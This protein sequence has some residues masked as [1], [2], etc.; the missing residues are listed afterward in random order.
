[1]RISRSRQASCAACERP[2]ARLHRFAA[3][4]AFVFER[5]AARIE[6]VERDQAAI[7]FGAR[8]RQ[9][10]LA[11]TEFARDFGGLF[12]ETLAA[13]RGFLRAGALAFELAEQIGMFAMRALDAA[14]RLR[15]ARARRP[16]ALRG[17]WRA[18][19]SMSRVF[20]SLRASSTRSCL[21]RCS[22]SSTP[23]CGSP[24]RL[25][26]SQ[27]R[28][29]HS[30]VRVMTDSSS[31][32][33]R[34]SRSASAKRFGEPHARQQPHDGGRAAD[35]ARQHA[36]VAIGVHVPAGLQQRDAADRQRRAARRPLRRV[37]RRTTLRDSRRARFRRRVPSRRSPTAARRAAAACRDP[38]KSATRRCANRRA[39][40]PP[41]A[42]L[43]ARRLRAR[44]FSRSVRAASRWL[45]G[46]ELRGAQFLRAVERRGS[47]PATAHRRCCAPAIPSRRAAPS[48]AEDSC[49]ISASRSTAR[50]S[51]CAGEPA[52]LVFELL[53]ARA[54]H[55]RGLVRGALLAI[56]SFP[57]LL[58]VGE[59]V[60]GGRQ[61]FAE[62]A[63]GGLRLRE[64][65]RQLFD[66][67]AQRG[68]F[69]LV[70][71]DVRVRARPAW[72]APARARCAAARAARA[73]A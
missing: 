13:Q 5:R 66:L 63:L 37:R 72:R 4:F 26:R 14:L 1:M 51:A 2:R 33:S 15:R 30:P 25:T 38:R 52:Q 44:R 39:A 67:G 49:A 46:V 41:S 65:R 20:S 55:L 16:R 61:V 71:I 10:V 22:R 64:V 9:R 43:R 35:H 31:A 59:R 18:R 47:A 17:R 11:E 36:G 29:I 7:E 54:L 45:L 57:A 69:A 19:A 8:A 58:P 3:F 40:A 42:V 32:S 53:D 50:R 23:E 27:S 6:R 62:R 24:P 68:D 48:S 34:R 21:T 73:C 56:E 12:F 70:A 60:F 28:P